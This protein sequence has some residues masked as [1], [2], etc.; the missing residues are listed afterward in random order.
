MSNTVLR[1]LY[2][3]VCL[4]TNNQNVS[5]SIIDTYTAIDLYITDLR[6]TDCV[7]VCTRQCSVKLKF[8]GTDTDTDTDPR[9]EVGVSSAHGSRPAAACSACH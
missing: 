3:H 6:R 9:A 1:I 8:H 4:L 7:H 5:L 2:S